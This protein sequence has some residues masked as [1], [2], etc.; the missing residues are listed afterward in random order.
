MLIG[1]FN[2]TQHFRR[3]IPYPIWER[4][5]KLFFRI[6]IEDFDIFNENKRNYNEDA[7]GGN[8]KIFD[9]HYLVFFL[10][11]DFFFKYSMKN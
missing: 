9:I 5:H 2:K 3:L 1:S 10:S 11:S 8:L 4:V 7:F 6:L